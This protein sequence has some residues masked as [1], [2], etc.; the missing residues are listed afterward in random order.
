MAADLGGGGLDSF[1][2]GRWGTPDS[3]PVVARGAARVAEGGAKRR[4]E[5]VGRGGGRPSP[6]GSPRGSGWV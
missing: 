5:R 4:R 6:V 2:C 1:Y 3:R